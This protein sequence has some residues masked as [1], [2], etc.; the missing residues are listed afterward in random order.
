MTS[1]AGDWVIGVDGG[2]TRTRAVALDLQGREVGRGEGAA[3]LVDAA[4]PER[5][6]TAVEQVSAAVAEAAGR[7]LPAA[8][9]WAGLAGA[10]REAARADV[11]KAL[12]RSGVSGVIH[13]DTDVR[14]AFH[15]AFADGSGLLL[16]AGTGS[17]AWG[18]SEDGREGRVGGW[19]HVIGDEG[20]GYAVG[21]EALRRVARTVD[22]RVAATALVEPVLTHLGLSDPSGI[23]AWMGSAS[24]SDVAALAPLVAAASGAGDQ[25]AS[26]ILADAV[27]DLEAH[28]RAIVETLGPWSEAPTVALTGGLLQPG[29]MLRSPLTDV[30][31]RLGLRVLE[32]ALDPAAGAARLALA[33]ATP[34]G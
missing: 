30:I 19:G 21:R 9:L 20:S 18:R 8:A 15:D 26:D 2:G 5:A 14:A 28:L 16:I 3:S 10:G 24:K 4:H 13:V 6:A 23:G 33:L 7:R 32:R 1:A 34:S 27:G 12:H 17:I 22:G 29:G 25:V 31:A 11:E